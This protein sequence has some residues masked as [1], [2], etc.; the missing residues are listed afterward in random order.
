MATLSHEEIL[1]LHSLIISEKETIEKTHCYRTDVAKYCS[2]LLGVEVSQNAVKTV[3]DS[4]GD[5]APKLKVPVDSGTV[6]KRI[7][8]L[9]S[10]LYKLRKAI[11]QTSD[12]LEKIAAYLNKLD[13][14]A[15]DTKEV[16]KIKDILNGK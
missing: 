16:E 4:M 9:H 6:D 10:H 5:D 8:S 12:C 11:Q 15:V 13:S 14:D 3:F 2:K 1:R 7:N